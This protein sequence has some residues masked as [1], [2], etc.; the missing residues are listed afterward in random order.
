MERADHQIKSGQIQSCDKACLSP[1]SSRLSFL[2]S[3]FSPEIEYKLA[4]KGVKDLASAVAAADSL[5]D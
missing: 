4:R 3:G 1:I 5:V 2:V